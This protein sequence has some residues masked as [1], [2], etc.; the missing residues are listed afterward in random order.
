MMYDR[1]AILN[2]V[3]RWPQDRSIR[4]RWPIIAFGAGAAAWAFSRWLARAP[5]VAEAY[6][7]RVGP[8]L[9]RPL[10]QL[11]GLV[12][13]SVAE[14]LVAAYV[15]WLLA[16]S[17]LAVRSVIRRQRQVRNTLAGGARRV[18]RDAGV[19]VTLFYV[20]WGFHYARAGFAE[21]AG[22]P[23]WNR[24]E[25][26]ELIA[27]TQAAIVAANQA[28][29]DLHD[30]DDA[31]RPTSVADDTL[32]IDEALAAGWARAASVLGLSPRF[33]ET[34]GPV[35]RPFSS[36]LLIRLGIVGIYVPFT[37][38]AN[39]LHGM[40][41]VGAVVAMAHEQAH[42][43]GVTGEGD[44]S[45]IGFVAA[46]LAPGRLGHYSAA[47]WAQNRLA[48]ALARADRAAYRRLSDTRL[49]G[50]RRDLNDLSEFLSRTTDIGQ[51]LQAA[52]NDRYLRANRVPGGVANYGLSTQLLITWAR[53]Q[54]GDPVPVSETG[55]GV[56][57]GG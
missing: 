56:R 54:G 50:V 6:G 10:S 11:T 5:A 16:V 4:W 37:A 30:T 55:P 3:L 44:A 29:R 20:L 34:Y 22:W 36:D 38:E 9:S 28:Y 24:A 53:L 21:R 23:E 39:T 33:V 45:F 14:W 13:F 32:G 52:V 2:G 48:T 19:L 43:R 1:E 7:T 40:P 41:P 35:K 25:T 31:G 42:Q 51:R 18:V 57:A 17:I 15:V 26:V 27:L 49:P 12:P 46:A 47:V 8:A